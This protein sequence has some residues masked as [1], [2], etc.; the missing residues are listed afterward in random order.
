MIKYNLKQYTYNHCQN[1]QCLICQMTYLLNAA[2][3]CIIVH[4]PLA[5]LFFLLD[6]DMKLDSDM[7]N[8]LDLDPDPP[9]KS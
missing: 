9:Q 5:T 1:D 4:L 8:G 3:S 6:Q 7:K 2:K